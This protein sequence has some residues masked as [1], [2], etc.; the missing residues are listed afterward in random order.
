MPTGIYH[1]THMDNVLSTIATG[2]L[3]AMRK[4]REEHRDYSTIAYESI[5]DHRASTRV[6]CGPGGVLHDYIPFYFAPRSPMLCA[7]SH[8]KVASCPNQDDVVHLVSAAEEVR[9]AGLGFALTD[10]HGIMA[11]TEF[12][13]DLADLDKID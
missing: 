13:D 8:G 11:W 7:I 10:G 3:L 4:L 5:Q 12:Y 9:D 2:A 1:S 6:P